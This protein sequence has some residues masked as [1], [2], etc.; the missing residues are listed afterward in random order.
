[1]H[2]YLETA[3]LLATQAGKIMLQ[4]FKIGVPADIKPDHS[5]VTL[6]D[7][8][9]NRLVIETISGKYDGHAVMGEEE[10]FEAKG[11][12][13]VW[14]CD[15]I[16]GTIPFAH[17]IPTNVFSLALVEDGRPVLGVVYDPHQKR[18]YSAE[19]GKG[20]YLNGKRLQV[21]NLNKLHKAPVGISGSWNEMLHKPNL[22][23][24]LMEEHMRTFNFQSCIYET[25]MVASG[26]FVGQLFGGKNA[27]DVATT[28][29]I[30]E[31]AGGKVTDLFGREQRYD[32]AIN[33][34]I[35]S[36][37]VMHEQLLSLVAPYTKATVHT[38]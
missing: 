6:A 33:G 32:R 18:M 15:P 20:A 5:P 21:N 16:D 37:G 22:V 30:V 26:E 2:Q 13:Y 9:V 34:A 27:H 14:V 10:S 31:E 36:N 4:H 3:T 11:A 23:K 35:V 7:T 8:E 24:H 12:T 28:K 17:G 25:M 29:I 1:M 38:K 19:K